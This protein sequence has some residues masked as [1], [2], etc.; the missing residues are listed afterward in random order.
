[1]E[2]ANATIYKLIN[3]LEAEIVKIS[4]STSKALADQVGQL[5]DKK[6]T[7]TSFAE[8]QKI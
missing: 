1:V 5:R 3:L 8:K 4:G 2:D 7:K 6:A